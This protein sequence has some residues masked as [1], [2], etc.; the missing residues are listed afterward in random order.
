M[1]EQSTRGV[2][3]G[4]IENSHARLVAYRDAGRA[5]LISAELSPGPV[6]PTQHRR[7]SPCSRCFVASARK[8]KRQPA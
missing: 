6:R 8:K 4:A 3:I 2:D 5:V 7:W 1:V